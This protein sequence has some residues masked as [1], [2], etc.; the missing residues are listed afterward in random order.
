MIALAALTFPLLATLS[1]DVDCGC[2]LHLATDP[3]RPVAVVLRDTEPRH[4]RGEIVATDF[5]G[6]TRTTRVD[7][8][9]GAGETVKVELPAPRRYGAWIVEAKM[10]D[11]ESP[12][13]TR[14]AVVRA[15]LQE[16]GPR[17]ARALPK[18]AFA[19]GCQIQL[20]SYSPE[21][22]RLAV[23]AAEAMGAQV[24]RLNFC[25]FKS[26]CEKG[27]DCDFSQAD[28]IMSLLEP[29]GVRV[30]AN[31][32]GTPHWARREEDRGKRGE[33]WYAYP[34]REGLYRDFCR[35]LA[36]HYGEKIAWYEIGN[37]W[38]L[39]PVD[40]LS[41]DEGV[42]VMREAYEGIKAGCPAAQV[43]PNGWAVAT[44]ASLS[45]ARPDFQEDIM[46]A[47]K[48][49]YD[50]HTI[51]IHGPYA[52]YVRELEKFFAW[53]K[54]RGVDAPWF[55][56]ETAL[57]CVNGQEHAAARDVWRKILYGW[58]HGAVSH[59]WYQLRSDGDNPKSHGD[60]YGL[61]TRRFYPRY[62]YG[63]YA[64]LTR[65]LNGATFA[66]AY[67]D[68]PE[69]QILRFKVL[70]GDRSEIVVVGFDAS[71]TR[72]S[73]DLRSGAARR[74][75]VAT[76]LRE[77]RYARRIFTYVG[78]ASPPPQMNEILQLPLKAEG[79][80]CIPFSTDAVRVLSYDLTGNEC[81]VKPDRDG[82][83]AL[84]IDETPTALRFIGATF[85]KTTCEEAT[86]VGRF[87]R[88]RSPSAQ[89][90]FLSAKPI[91]L[92]PAVRMRL[93]ATFEHEAGFVPRLHTAGGK[94]HAIRLNGQS[95]ENLEGARVGENSLE[96][97]VTAG[98]FTAEVEE[99][100]KTCA[101]TP[102]GFDVKPIGT[103]EVK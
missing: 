80:V 29:M 84:R 53:R 57:T 41:L 89:A 78:E 67:C 12:A 71:L 17:G 93:T 26:V 74:T 68:T 83:V 90:S 4:W 51:H 98:I 65:L 46:T 7:R 49:F 95:V 11:G 73:K 75:A 39:L 1:L 99:S 52:H 35:A 20:P 37:E 55:P 91:R 32:Y 33:P 19:M 50:A 70:R 38:D 79:A 56:N 61:M 40:V 82:R 3:A 47:A 45:Q 23:R 24:V 59:S 88:A 103:G 85:A 92:D 44:G 54:A 8:Q 13:A 31:I 101:A 10:D 62:T 48:G 9:S 60:N 76:S 94:V 58:A 22:R 28:E 64:A 36:A 102:E 15:G 72:L 69:R 2:P 27:P 18:T 16:D 25:S 96:L 77:A 42:R 87:G 14:F 30:C 97:E 81:E 66:G 34:P 86:D 5:F 100:G 21:D 6:T 43:I 63:A